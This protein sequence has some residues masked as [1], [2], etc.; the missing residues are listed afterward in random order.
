MAGNALLHNLP[1]SLIIRR[2]PQVPENGLGSFIRE[3][4]MGTLVGIL[5]KPHQV[6]ITTHPIIVC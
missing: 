5:F 6:L 2:E 4:S 3:G 1:V